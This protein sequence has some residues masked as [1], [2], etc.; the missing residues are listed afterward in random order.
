[1]DRLAALEVFVQVVDAGSFSAVARRQHIG[2]PAVSKA[3]A[4]LEQWLGVSL[5]LRS[6]RSV[7][8]TEAGQI[9]YE[10]AKRTI[11]EA[12][13]AVMAA[14]GSAHGL[15]GKLRVSTSI[16]FGRLHV[17]PSLSVFL[18]EHPDLELELVLDDRFVDLV[19]E[20][21][22]VALRTGA[23]PSSNMTA[24]RI[25]EGRSLVVATPAYLQRH[26]TPMSPAEL[27]SHQAV[28]L[29]RGGGRDSFTFRK[30]D[31]E[32]SVTLQGRLK[33]TQGE[34][35]REAVNSDLGLA[36][37]AE[38]LFSPE[39]KSG[40]VVPILQDW[41]LP[42]TPLSAVYPTGRLAGAK[43]RTFVAF[44]ERCIAASARSFGAASE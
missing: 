43:A 41:T 1:M 9:F 21:V 27:A 26:G 12:D 33:V 34:G 4:Q 11:E 15:T 39:L 28:I 42:P 30:A 5:L 31:A 20:G 10:R 18:A 22:D 2:Q 29:T 8:P 6:T 44:V 37:A 25:A 7:V 35:V 36:V 32:V 3:V 40:K 17:I 19:N 14:Q 23:M 16:C 13:E 38:W 24:R